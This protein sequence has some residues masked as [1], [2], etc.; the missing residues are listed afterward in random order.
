MSGLLK[1]RPEEFAE[2]LLAGA[3]SRVMILGGSGNEGP[4]ASTPEF[5][6]LAEFFAGDRQTRPRQLQSTQPGASSG[7]P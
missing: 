6:A 4:R 2:Q 7:P 5:D 1:L 3:H